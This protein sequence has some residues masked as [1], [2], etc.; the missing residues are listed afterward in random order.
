MPYENKASKFHMAYLKFIW[1][2]RINEYGQVSHYSLDVHC[3]DS[4]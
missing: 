4:Q 3:P 1:I 2:I